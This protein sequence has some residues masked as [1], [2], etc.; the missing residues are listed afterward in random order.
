[1]ILIASSTLEERILVEK[2]G[3]IKRN[4]KNLIIFRKKNQE[5]NSTFQKTNLVRYQKTTKFEGKRKIHK[6]RN[7]N[8]INFKKFKVS[9][10]NISIFYK[11]FQNF[12]T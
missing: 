1:M 3:F 10:N 4:P 5:K 6:K 11:Y 12:W 7:I 8:T 9:T 2:L